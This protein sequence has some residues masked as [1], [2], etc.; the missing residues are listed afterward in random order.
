MKYKKIGIACAIL[1]AVIGTI[2]VV[3]CGGGGNGGGLGAGEHEI[4]KAWWSTT[5]EIKKDSDDKIIY[6]NVEL[7]LTTV[8][9]GTDMPAFNSIISRFNVTHPGIT[10]VA[11][12]ETE[13][14][15][16]SE[17]AKK[18]SNN[19]NAPD[20]LMTHQKEMKSLADSKLIQPYNEV[21]E[22]SGIEINLENYANGLTQYSSLNF[23]DQMFTVPVDMHSIAVL[24]NKELLGQ[25]QLPSTHAELLELC[26]KVKQEKNIT[27]IAAS[28]HDATFYRYVF[29]TAIMQNGGTFFD[30]NTYNANWATGSNAESYKNAIA[31]IR[32]LITENVMTRQMSTG[33]ALN[34][35]LNNKALF[36]FVKP[37]EVQSVVNSYG[38]NKENI[39][40]TDISGWFAMNA[41]APTANYIF[42]DS[43]AIAISKT[44]TDITKKAAICEFVKWF[45][46]NSS[47]GANWADAGHMSASKIMTSDTQ[48][49]ANTMVSNYLSKFYP[50]VDNFQTM[51]ISPYTYQYKSYLEQLYLSVIGNNSASGDEAAISQYQKKVNDEIATINMM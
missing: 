9:A 19:S 5:G 51:G 50:N 34:A 1:G 27:P 41:N 7:K 47:A 29:S 17:V 37:W 3:G 20:I 13:E 39:S 4:D 40:G 18:I 32:D 23:K 22:L 26:K 6:N 36:Y 49:K 28:T 2:S 10:V 38:G 24:Y 15:F 45:S 12:S 21:L 46:E 25:E 44:V 48:Y 16:N 33:D 8:V 31:S 30:E 35:F 11:T 43:H 42:G 14:L